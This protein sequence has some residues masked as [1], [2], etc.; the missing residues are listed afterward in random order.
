[1]IENISKTLQ[2]K[3]KFL[4]TEDNKTIRKVFKIPVAQVQDDPHQIFGEIRNYLREHRDKIEDFRLESYIDPESFSPV[5]VLHVVPI[6]EVRKHLINSFWQNLV[7]LDI[8][9]FLIGENVESIVQSF[10]FEFN[11][12][13]MRAQLCS[14]IEQLL[15]SHSSATFAIEDRTTEENTDQGILNIGATYEGEFMS[16]EDLV[17]LLQRKNML[18]KHE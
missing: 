4:T 6:Q 9:A 10:S 1:M 18:S 13:E 7:H 16:I 17:L 12:P 5:I 3:L 2:E 8:R 15:K 11:T 14:L